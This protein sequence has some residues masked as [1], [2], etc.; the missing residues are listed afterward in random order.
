MRRNTH[1]GISLRAERHRLRGRSSVT[2][3]EQSFLLGSGLR[4]PWRSELGYMPPGNL[5]SD[6]STVQSETSNPGLEV[7]E[8]ILFHG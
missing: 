7:Q 8:S 5:R 4:G 2:M 3:N 6:D 1:T